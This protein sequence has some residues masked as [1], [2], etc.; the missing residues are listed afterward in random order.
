MLASQSSSISGVNFQD[1]LPMELPGAQLPADPMA[2]SSGRIT[3]GNPREFNFGLL[4]AVCPPALVDSVI[5]EV[6]QR[7]QR[8]RRLPS[9]L[10]VYA[11][12]FMAFSALAYQKLLCHLTPL[13]GNWQPPNKASFARARAK[14]GWEVMQRLF[15][16]VR[17]VAVDASG[18][19]CCAWPA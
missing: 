8:C 6:G 15:T 12:I 7:E 17:S 4:M 11:L 14:L 2:A 3:G 9:R 5:E 16:A 10:L 18:R 1:Q 19:R 13:T